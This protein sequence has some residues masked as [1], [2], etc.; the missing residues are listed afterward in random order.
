MYDVSQEDKP[1]VSNP[2]YRDG[3]YLARF[4]RS[5]Q[6]IEQAEIAPEPPRGLEHTKRIPLEG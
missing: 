4:R 5:P 6:R 3:F 2:T 1:C